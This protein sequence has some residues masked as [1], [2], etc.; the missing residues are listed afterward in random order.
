MD[1][2]GLVT[3]YL[4]TPQ[5]NQFGG[6]CASREPMVVYGMGGDV[7]K[8]SVNGD[9]PV[10]SIVAAMHDSALHGCDSF[11]A[12]F[13]AMAVIGDQTPIR[14]NEATIDPRVRLSVVAMRFD[15]TGVAYGVATRGVNDDGTDGDWELTHVDELIATPSRVETD[16][17]IAL[18]VTR[19]SRPPTVARRQLP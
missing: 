19:Q 5:I 9:R 2:E 1:L 14:F 4:D 6:K 18:W 13:E 11:G 3:L 7:L 16:R 17:M 15:D 12:V 10:D 8:L